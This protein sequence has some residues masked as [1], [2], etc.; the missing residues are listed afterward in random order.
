MLC[1]AAR[2]TTTRCERENATRDASS[3]CTGCV[4]C[5]VTSRNVV[6]CN[7]PRRELALYRGGEATLEARPAIVLANKA[8]GV[9]A[10]TLW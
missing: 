10:T 4:T 6:Q 5:A 3:R 1:R 7:G 9:V 8:G 2:H